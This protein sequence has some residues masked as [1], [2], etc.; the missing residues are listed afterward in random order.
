[1]AQQ[2]V[3]DDARAKLLK[4]IELLEKRARAEK[5]P[6]KKLELFE[7]LKELKGNL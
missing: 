6:R 4:Q 1:M 5:Q 7:R 3:I 2:I